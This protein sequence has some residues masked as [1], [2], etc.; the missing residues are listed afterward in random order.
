MRTIV[1]FYPPQLQQKWKRENPRKG[2]YHNALD[3][4][5]YQVAYCSHILQ[6][7]GVEELY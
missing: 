1:G 6:E 3:D 2:T 7:L 5:K 4:A